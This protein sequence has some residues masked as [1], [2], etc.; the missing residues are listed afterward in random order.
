M[1]FVFT[2]NDVRA[3]SC[4]L[5]PGHGPCGVV[6]GSQVAF[7]TR[8]LHEA[9]TDDTP[10]PRAAPTLAEPIVDRVKAFLRRNLVLYQALHDLRMM[11]EGTINHVLGRVPPRWQVYLDPPSTA[12]DAAWQVTEAA[13]RA[14]R[15]EQVVNGGRLAIVAIP[16]PFVTAPDWKRKLILGGGT[17]MPA[18]FDPQRPTRHLGEIASRLDVPFLDLTAVFAAYRREHDLPAPYFAFACDGHWNPLGH[19]LAAAAV[20]SFL[21][22][23]RFLPGSPEVASLRRTLDE[24]MTRSPE[25][26]LGDR[27]FRQIYR[28]GM[29]RPGD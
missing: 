28:G 24:L 2:G 19:R 6:S 11:V 27:A 5:A 16:E 12:W 22:D 21:A 7:R 8:S 15:D 17:G 14:L 13:I 1:L 18:N 23:H 20:A 9:P 29:Y 4:A 25:N 3:N 26:I 10:G